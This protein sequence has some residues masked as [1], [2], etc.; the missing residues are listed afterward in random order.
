MKR[1][2]RPHLGGFT[3]IE[4][5]VAVALVAIVATLAVRRVE[6]VRERART[7]VA[8]H[9]LRLIRDA[10]VG[11]SAAPGYLDDMGSVPGFSPGY[12]R[13]ANLLVAT[14]LHAYGMAR[15][16]SPA[17]REWDA[18]A[19]RGWRGP[20]VRIDRPGPGGAPVFPS[21]SD[22]RRPGAQTFGECGFF[23]P[24]ARLSLPHDRIAAG[25]A[26]GYPG[27]P[28][29]FDPWGSPYVLQVPPSQAFAL[30]GG[31]LA[32]VSDEERFRYAR[33]V[34]A[35]PDG[36]LSTP[37][38]YANTNEVA[39]SWTEAKRR[40]SVFGGTAAQRGDDL[41]LFLLRA[42]IPGEEMPY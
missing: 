7:A 5:V 1:R 34:S 42:D 21:P 27:E 11:S 41:V 37:C 36:I 12:L 17:L 30:T 20:Y 6:G 16:P 33:V 18:A 2:S 29:L 14:N 32:D 15:D 13:L 40:A 8:A 39:S 24:L 23:P 22:R 3:L 35:G 19:G 25:A 38:Y 10:I 4:L 9:E 31:R 28:A 26:Y